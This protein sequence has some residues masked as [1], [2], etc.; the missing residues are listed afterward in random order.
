M[1]APTGW[2]MIRVNSAPTPVSI[3]STCSTVNWRPAPWR[4]A[5]ITPFAGSEVILVQLPRLAACPT[6]SGSRTGALIGA[7]LRPCLPALD[8]PDGGGVGEQDFAGS[9]RKA[10]RGHGPV[11]ATTMNTQQCRPRSAMCLARI[12]ANGVQQ[13]LM[14]AQVR[15]FYLGALV[16]CRAS[17]EL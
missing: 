5:L 7:E 9:C 11:M 1:S 2:D 10:R 14:T 12:P 13:H 8:C 17:M 16:S 4:T 6:H 15:S 3:P